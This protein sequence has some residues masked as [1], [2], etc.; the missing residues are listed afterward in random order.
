MHGSPALL[1]QAGDRRNESPIMNAPLSCRSHARR[2]IT[3]LVSAVDEPRLDE[4]VKLVDISMGNPVRHYHSLAHAL[5]V[6][7]SSD[8]LEVLIGL[9]HDIAQIEVDGGLPE[10]GEAWLDGFVVHDAA[11]GVRL[12]DD[13]RTRANRCFEIVRIG[14]RF[15]P[16]HVFVPFGGKNE[17]LSALIAARVLEPVIGPADLAALTVGI[18]ATIPFRGSAD[19]VALRALSAL[20]E[21]DQK[22]A[23]NMSAADR[24]EHVRR[25]IRIANRDVGSFGGDDLIAFL[26]DT[27]GLMR[28]S[29]PELRYLRPIGFTAYRQTVQ[30]MTRF[31]SSLRASVVFR[32]FDGEPDPQSFERLLEKTAH[33]LEVITAVMHVKL[34]ASA[35]LEAANSAVPTSV[36]PARITAPHGVTPP[37][38]QAQTIDAVL[39]I[40]KDSAVE[41]DMSNSPLAYRIVKSM[42]LDQVMALGGAIDLASAVGSQILEQVPR[43]VADAARAL[44]RSMTR[45]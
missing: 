36:I 44:A 12:I 31:L 26:D 45:T 13:A 4:L 29:S 16:G 34:L 9:C 38:S 33:N 28:E 27:W 8:P 10:G 22:F 32:R 3:A 5:M 15:A 24:R 41:S 14:F 39:A 11:G 2:A 1:V 40:G 42:K 6:A 30:K 7:D 18:E 37:F 17:F 25:S 19:D 35:L 20:E 43:D 21:I 23:L